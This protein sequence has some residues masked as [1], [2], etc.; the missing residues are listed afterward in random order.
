MYDPSQDY[1]NESTQSTN[2]CNYTQYYS[3][4]DMRAINY[5]DNCSTS[6]C[7]NPNTNKVHGLLNVQA[8]GDFIVSGR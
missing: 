3:D 2:G 8:N 1:L 7:D 4:C 5:E 6:G